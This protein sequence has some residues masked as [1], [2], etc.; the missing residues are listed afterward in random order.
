MSVYTTEQ[1]AEVVHNAL[2]AL[3][4]VNG[5]DHPTLPWAQAEDA[6]REATRTAVAMVR[7]GA[8]ADDLHRSWTLAK[9]ARG[10]TPGAVKDP[11]ARTHPCLGRARADLPYSDQVK[12]LVVITLTRVLTAQT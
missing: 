1:V 8:T 10:W 11:V 12:D 4:I 2:R 3:Q 5:E 9:L 6:D 7:D